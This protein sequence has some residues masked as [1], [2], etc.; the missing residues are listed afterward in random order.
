MAFYP[1]SGGAE[2][3]VATSWD[4]SR[5]PRAG[6]EARRALVAVEEM[7]EM[8]RGLDSAWRSVCAS[9]G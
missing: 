3:S 6:H 4:P 1:S 7:L 2:I 8:S 5:G 9:E